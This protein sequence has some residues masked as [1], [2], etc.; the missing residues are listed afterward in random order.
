MKGSFIHPRELLPFTIMNTKTNPKQKG[1]IAAQKVVPPAPRAWVPPTFAFVALLLLLTVIFYHKIVL[2]IGNLWEDMIYQEFPHRIF[3]HDALSHLSFPFWNPYTFGG[4][5]FFA[6]I[7]TGVLYPGNFLL[8]FMPFDKGTFW[9]AL[10][11]SI[12]LHVFIAGLAMF[13][14]CKKWSLSRS[15]SLFAAVSYMLCGFFTVHIIHSLMVYILAWLPMIMFFLLRG[16]RESRPKDFIYAGLILGLTIFAGHPQITFYE[17]LFLG[18]FAFYLV[19]TDSRHRVRDTIMMV[20]MFAIAGGLAMIQLLPAAELS[21]ESARVT[22]TYQMASE[23]S[24]S[25]RQLFTFIIPKLFGGTTSQNPWREE[26][27]FWLKDSFHSGYW[28]FWE[29]TFYTGLLALVFGIVQFVNVLRSRFALFCGAWC[30]F[31]LLFA[32][33]DH[34][35]LYKLLFDHVPG[36]G[37]FRDPARILFTWNLLVPLM[38]ALT[39]DGMKDPAERRR[40]LIPLAAAGAVCLLTGIAVSSG[41]AGTFCSEFTNDTIRQYAFKQSNIMIGILIAGGVATFLFYKSIINHRVF[42]L[43]S[44]ALLCLDLFIFGM[45]YHI[46]PQTATQYF[47]R[48]QQIAETLADE[49]RT[50]LFRTKMR[51]GGMMLLDRNQG[52]IDKIQLME[53]YNPLNLFRRLA[54]APAQTQLDLHNV[55]YAINIDRVADTVGLAI[56][57]SCMPRAKMFYRAQ[58]VSD[59]SL[60]KLRMA[61]PEFPY[62]TELLLSGQPGLDLPADTTEPNNT[63]SVTRYEPNRIE[64]TASTEKNGILWLSEI[65]YPAWKA[66][67]DGKETSILRADYSFRAIALPKGDH[68]VVFVYSSGTF[69]KGAMV[70]LLTLILAVGMIGFFSVKRP[71]RES[72]SE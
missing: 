42:L 13:Y 45:D 60:V 21:K 57:R 1:K 3:A 32:L 44:V 33:G 37:T 36:F 51:E 58:V 19:F 4:M 62:R 49:S 50:E 25:F 23:G 12:V 46:V 17:F 27:T 69:K 39:I 7:H 20:A 14:L 40:F 11:L 66:F 64:I 52:M 15:A 22:W 24:M 34:F 68:K 56:N 67:V 61:A 70:S 6:A 31:S 38:A 65:W 2:G 28:T 55:K 30:L 29:T 26:L 63:V 54:P 43:C 71:K 48:D 5:P 8:S 35:P 47:S 18:A 72:N 9:Y 16:V 41:L 59:D 53:G 10:E